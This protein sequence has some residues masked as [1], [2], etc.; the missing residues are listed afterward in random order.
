MLGIVKMRPKDENCLSTVTQWEL[1]ARALSLN[2]CCCCH[3]LPRPGRKEHLHLRRRR[4]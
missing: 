3:N 4:E 2:Y 1:G